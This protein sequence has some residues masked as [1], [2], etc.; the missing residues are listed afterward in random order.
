[1]V[2]SAASKTSPIYSPGSN[3]GKTAVILL[4]LVITEGELALQ[5]KLSSMI[6]PM[7]TS[8]LVPIETSSGFSN[9]NLKKMLPPFIPSTSTS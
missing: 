7:T 2:L 6:V 8:F 5:K 4:P 3:L 1:M 9:L